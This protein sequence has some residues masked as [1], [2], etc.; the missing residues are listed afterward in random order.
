MEHKSDLEVH[1]PQP[2]PKAAA[3]TMQV[4]SHCN[5]EIHEDLGIAFFTDHIT[6]LT[7]GFDSKLADAGKPLVQQ[8]GNKMRRQRAD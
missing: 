7:E 5:G 1:C 4:S 6:A 3:L 8:L 2:Y